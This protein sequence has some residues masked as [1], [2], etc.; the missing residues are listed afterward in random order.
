[1]L[2]SWNGSSECNFRFTHFNYK[3]FW[4]WNLICNKNHF[5]W[6]SSGNKLIILLWGFASLT[7]LQ[8]SLRTIK[9]RSPLK[10]RVKYRGWCEWS[11]CFPK[12]S[13]LL[14]I[15]SS[16]VDSEATFQYTQKIT[17]L[18][19]SIRLNLSHERERCPL[20]Y[21]LCKINETKHWSIITFY[22]NR[23]I[24]TKV[25]LKLLFHAVHYDMTY[26]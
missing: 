20:A 16:A 10:V 25:E 19:S 5:I 13:W 18:N 8:L 22:I 7:Y 11:N 2:P 14:R 26:R 12:R 21:K 15:L 1:M 23:T 9:I 24:C 6:R 17:R 3:L 4:T